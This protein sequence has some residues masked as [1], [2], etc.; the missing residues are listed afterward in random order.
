MRRAGLRAR[1]A[2][3]HG[4]V[5]AAILILTALVADR[6]LVRAV[7][8]QVDARLLA[9]AQAEAAL[10]LDDD[11]DEAPRLRGAHAAEQA[12]PM[13]ADALAQIV[14]SGGRVID[15]SASLSGGAL[16]VS[17]TLFARLAEGRPVFETA[18]GP[19]GE[20]LRMVSLPVASRG[21]LRYAIQVATPLSSSLAALRTARLLFAGAAAAIL[22]AVVA[23]G[24]LLARR[25][26][27][28]IDDVV[29][30]AREIGESSL[31]SRL[32]HPGTRDEVGRLVTTL[33]EMLARIERGV[34]A[35]RR[36][37]AD[38]SHELR[39]PLSRLRTEIE[40]TLRRPRTAEAYAAALRS[41]LEEVGRLTRLTSALLALARLDAG[42][43]PAPGEPVTL[44]P[45]VEA[46][47]RRLA[48]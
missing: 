4:F 1:L 11:D 21:R 18:A 5:V 47:A 22:V 12:P 46:E 33:N 14:S 23:S 45:A 6:L 41:G 27:R 43:A 3:W 8:D 48:P 37:T 26:L 32:P 7:G 36:F 39:S 31:A 2:V 35:Q 16:P 44:G 20:P 10:A 15:R 13:R 19:A 40:V 29:A 38:A 30:K 24:A 9:T 34:E 17:R 42:E 28:P 25:A